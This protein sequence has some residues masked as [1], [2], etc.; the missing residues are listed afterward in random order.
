MRVCHYV[1][2]NNVL[3][4]LQVFFTHLYKGGSNNDRGTLVQLR[5]LINRRNVANDVSG[6]FNASIDFFELV[7]KCHIVA[8]AMDFFGMST[9]QDE[10]TCNQCFATRH[11][12]VARQ[13]ESMEIFLIHHWTDG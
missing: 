10:P 4:L 1:G 12:P 13:R 5:N 2:V 11:P 8:A 3:D 7:T 9:P 6:R